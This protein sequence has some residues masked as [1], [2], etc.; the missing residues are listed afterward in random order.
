MKAIDQTFKS[1][2]APC[3]MDK[4]DGRFVLKNP[5]FNPTQVIN[6]LCENRGYK[7]EY[8][9]QQHNIPLKQGNMDDKFA[10]IYHLSKPSCPR[11]K[12][13][14]AD[15][16][17]TLDTPEKKPTAAAAPTTN[18]PIPPTRVDSLSNQLDKADIN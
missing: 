13:K 17:S 15:S 4:E 3:Q 6:T 5:G 14:H 1:I 2:D 9:P 7:I 18:E 11:K 8:N 10:I 12:V 16:T